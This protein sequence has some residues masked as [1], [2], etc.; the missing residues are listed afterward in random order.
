MNEEQNKAISL[1]IAKIIEER[2]DE[3]VSAALARLKEKVVAEIDWSSNESIRSTVKTWLDTNIV[4]EINK[5]LDDEKEG[6]LAG[7]RANIASV[8]AEIGLGLLKQAQEN[9]AESWKRRSAL[10]ALF[11]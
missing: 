11:D 4:P 10:K 5:M 9:M 2:K 3:L 1:D 6:I 8:G 7:L